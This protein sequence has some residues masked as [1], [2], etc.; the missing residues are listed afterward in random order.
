MISKREIL[1]PIQLILT[2]SL[3]TYLFYTTGKN[4][5][6][7][8]FDKSC[9]HEGLE[10]T[11]VTSKNMEILLSEKSMCSFRDYNNQNVDSSLENSQNF[12]Q[13]NEEKT[14]EPQLIELSEVSQREIFPRS[15]LI[16]FD[17]D[18]FESVNGEQTFQDENRQSKLKTGENSQKNESFDR[19]RVDVELSCV[20]KEHLV[21]D[22][23][24]QKC[25]REKIIRSKHCYQCEA[26]VAKFDHHCCWIG[27]CV[28]EL[29]HGKY[30]MLLASSACHQGQLSTYTFDS[31][32]INMNYI[33]PIDK[34]YGEKQIGLFIICFLFSFLGFQF[35]FLLFIYHSY[36]L[37][38]NTTTL[39]HVKR[40]KLDYMKNYKGW[41]FPYDL[42]F[43]ENVKTNCCGSGKKLR[44]WDLSEFQSKNYQR[45]VNIC[46]NKYYNLC[47]L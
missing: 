43:I 4:P 14:K 38:I 24:C 28:G 16:I 47:T 12:R 37:W 17:N 36:L 39:E 11:E 30:W 10:L 31:I 40:N 42:G 6:Y 29:N 44:N 13:I 3:S 18:S 46:E 25:N 7:I 1:F 21:I 34:N 33:D 35:A 22:V 45:T 8:S 19:Q 32:M 9:N 27:S 5:G 23:F 20:Q 15:E 2:F 26:C 41:E